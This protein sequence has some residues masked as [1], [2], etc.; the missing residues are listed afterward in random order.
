M[1]EFRY[2]LWLGIWNTLQGADPGEAR[3]GF[4]SVVI[5]ADGEPLSLEIAGWS[6]AAIGASEPVYMKSVASAA[7][8]YYEITIDHLRVIAAARD[9]RITTT[10]PKPKSFEPWD[11]QRA[12]KVS[13]NE[14]LNVSVY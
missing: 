5:F 7:D 10:G 3:D 1:G 6:A 14:F 2:F 9:V 4:E 13:L 11:Q 8:A 12:A